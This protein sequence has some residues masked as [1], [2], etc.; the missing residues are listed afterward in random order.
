MFKKCVICQ[1]TSNPDII[2]GVLNYTTL[3]LFVV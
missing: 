3:S 2:I 1:K